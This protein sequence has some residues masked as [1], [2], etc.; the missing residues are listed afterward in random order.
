MNIGLYRASTAIVLA[1]LFALVTPL[2]TMAQTH[3]T[4]IRM[5]PLRTTLNER[6]A[7]DAGIANTRQQS[8]ETPFGVTPSS[9]VTL[10][11]E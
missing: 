3:P 6:L 10:V 2:P 11:L 5:L 4:E 8:D 1:L 9:I 7:E